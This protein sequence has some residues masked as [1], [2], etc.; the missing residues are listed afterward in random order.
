MTTNYPSALDSF[1]NP[2]ATDAL[3]SAT[4]PHAAQ[5][6]NINDAMAAVQVTL[7]V[8]PQGG[9]ATVVAR[10]TAL[11]STVAGKAS[12]SA[13][14]TFT[15]GAQT[16]RAG[17]D[18]TKILIL[19]RNSV[20]Q[21]ANI[22]SVVQ[23]DGTTE[24]ARIRPYGQI[25]VGSLITNALV[26]INQDQVGDNRGIVIKAGVTTPAN[27]AIEILPLA[28]NTAVLSVTHGGNIT[29]AGDI[30]STATTGSVTAGLLNATVGTVTLGTI[31][32]NSRIGT[33]NL[34]NGSDGGKSQIF[35]RTGTSATTIN[36]LPVTSGTIA[37]LNDITTDNLTGTSLPNVT[38]VRGTTIPA[39]STLITSATTSLPNITSVNSTTI[40]ASS[41]LITSATTSLP[42]VTSVNGSTIPASAT[43]VTSTAYRQSQHTPSGSV[44]IVPRYQVSGTR[45]M[46]S[47]TMYFTGFTPIAD[48]TLTKITTVITAVTGATSFQYGLF[49]VSGT[50]VTCIASTATGTPATGLL[51]LSFGSSQSMTAGSNYAIGFLAVGGTSVTVAGVT[52]QANL[53]LQG[54]GTAGTVLAPLLAASSNSTTLTSMPSAGATVALGVGNTASFAFARLN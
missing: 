53:V 14:N 31:S 24:L 22:V 48:L 16:I 35:P 21:S 54:N 34:Y 37:A 2:T 10:L 33:I 43:L 50:T 8:N 42:N 11:D 26:A 52:V 13:A 17:S 15:T 27:N 19:Q 3:D 1:V 5:H 29:T 23:S 18:A 41:T 38:S 39:S 44:D 30:T 49:S 47:G 9:S 20:S 40:P 7:G 25:G 28:S 4:V 12:L 6:D 51:E 36:Y 32:D 46:T 45:A